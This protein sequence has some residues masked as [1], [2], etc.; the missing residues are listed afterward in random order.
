MAGAIQTTTIETKSVVRPLKVISLVCLSLGIILMI[1]ALCS[2]WWLKSGT[3]RT[4]LFLECTSSD[5]KRSASPLIGAPAP[6]KCHAPGRDS[7]L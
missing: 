7:G 1:I 5:E 2:T 3:F 4:G 6:G